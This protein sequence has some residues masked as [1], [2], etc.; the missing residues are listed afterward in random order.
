MFFFFSFNNIVEFHP[1]II[2]LTGDEEHIHQATKAYR[3]YYS[4]G[5]SDDDDDYLVYDLYS[6]TPLPLGPFDSRGFINL[7]SG[8]AE[9]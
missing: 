1:R 9:V 8:V 5:P 3:V 7:N 4:R 2:G 6:G